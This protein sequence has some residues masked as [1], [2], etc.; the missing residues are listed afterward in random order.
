MIITK[1]SKRKVVKKV[2]KMMPVK[3]A[4][5]EVKRL[6]AFIDLYKNYTPKKQDPNILS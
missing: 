3:K 4:K 6:Q 5:E 1:D 2:T